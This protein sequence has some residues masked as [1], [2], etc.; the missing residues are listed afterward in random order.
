M[1]VIGARCHELRIQ[2]EKQTWRVIYRVDADAVVIAE[3]FAKT[4]QTTPSSVIKN[5]QRR[6]DAYDDAVKG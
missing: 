6:L 3:V 1:P 5:S 2:D 4:T